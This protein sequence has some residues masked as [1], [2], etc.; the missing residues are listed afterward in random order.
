MCSC[1]QGFTVINSVGREILFRLGG[2]VL[3]MTC[4]TPRFEFLW[5]WVFTILFVYAADGLRIRQE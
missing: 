4:A 3:A 5:G 1:G 2:G